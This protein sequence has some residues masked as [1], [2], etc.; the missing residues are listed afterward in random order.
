MDPPPP[1]PRT[2]KIVLIGDSG[3]GKSALHQRYMTNRFSREYTATLGCSYQA[4]TIDV[5]GVQLSLQLWD[6][7]GKSYWGGTVPGPGEWGRVRLMS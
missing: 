2:A 7:A 3:T 5:N 4:K 6:T 1:R